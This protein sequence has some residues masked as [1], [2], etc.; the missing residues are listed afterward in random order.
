MG[1]IYSRCG[2]GHDVTFSGNFLKVDLKQSQQD[3]ISDAS[4]AYLALVRVADT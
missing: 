4:R 2:F 3:K 1:M